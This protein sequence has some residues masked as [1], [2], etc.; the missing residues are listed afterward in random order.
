MAEQDQQDEP[1][2]GTVTKDVEVETTVDDPGAQREDTVARERSTSPV[3]RVGDTWEDMT[4]VGTQGPQRRVGVLEIDGQDCLVEN[5]VTRQKSHVR[6][7]RFVP[8]NWRFI[9]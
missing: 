6:I 7:D 2:T 3:P 5:K 1:R 4:D 9:G 8:P